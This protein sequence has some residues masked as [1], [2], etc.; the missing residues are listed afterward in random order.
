[1]V[2]IISLQKQPSRGVKNFLKTSQNTLENTCASVFFNEVVGLNFIKKDTLAQVLPCEFRGIY[3]TPF[4][5]NASD[6]CVLVLEN[7]VLP[8]YIVYFH[9]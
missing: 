4:L 9:L 7:L 5:K 6:G 3:K 8:L 2:A 1:M